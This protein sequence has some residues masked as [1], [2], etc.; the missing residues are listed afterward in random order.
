MLLFDDESSTYNIKARWVVI[1]TY[2][3]FTFMN[4]YMY[5]VYH[6][7]QNFQGM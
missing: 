2:M 3:Y 6:K 4:T 5:I 1:S 7:V